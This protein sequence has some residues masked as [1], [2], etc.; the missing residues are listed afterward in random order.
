MIDRW[1]PTALEYDLM[2]GED[3]ELLKDDIRTNGQ[4]EPVSYRVLED[5]TKQGLDGRNRVNACAELGIDCLYLRED[6][7][8]EEAVAFIKSRNDVRRH[9][10]PEFRERR[11][12]ERIEREV[13]KRRDGESTRQI[14]EEEGVSQAQVRLDLAK[15][16]EQGCSV[17]PDGGKVTGKDGKKRDA[18]RAEEEA[19][20]EEKRA[21][22]CRRLE[23][24]RRRSAVDAWGIPIQ[25]HAQEAFAAL[26]QFEELASLLRKC[27]KLFHALADSPGGRFLTRTGAATYFRK[28]DKNDEGRFV[29]KGLEKAAYDLKNAVP[30]H[31][32]CPYHYVDAPHGDDCNCCFNLGWTPPL[33]DSIPSMCKRRAQK[34]FGVEEV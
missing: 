13:E 10:T 21:A 3:F 11:R 24:E 32:V 6:F 34:A 33:G 5:G 9:D 1:H 14:A 29:H 7:S 15:A 31:T 19:Q 30:T 20:A 18:K 8:D 12:Q 26:P 28:R 4:I 17:E 2:E 23:E 27:Q 25:P 22:E 16:T